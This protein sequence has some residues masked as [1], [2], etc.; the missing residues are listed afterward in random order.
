MGNDI[1]EALESHMGESNDFK[2]IE[3]KEGIV[4]KKALENSGLNNLTG[5]KPLSKDALPSKMMYNSKDSV[6]SIKSADFSE[7][8]YYSSMDEDDPQSVDLAINELLSS[9][10]KVKGG[11]WRDLTLTDKL[12]VF[13]QIRDYTMLNTKSKNEVT[14]DFASRINGEKVTKTV[15]AALFDHHS[16]DEDLMR[17]Y[18]ED[19]RSFVIDL[20]DDRLEIFVPKVG[21]VEG[22]KKYVEKVRNEASMKPEVYLDKNFAVAL[23]YLIKEWRDI[24]DDFTYVDRLK[25]EYDSWSLEKTQVFNHAVSL[26]KVGVKPTLKVKFTN[27]NVEVFPVTFRR[28]KSLFYISDRI[29]KLFPNSK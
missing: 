6:V 27:G 18:N 9:C 24:D 17:L 20:D 3:S 14:I 28:Y 21:V 26:L 10:C 2:K 8:K 19:S 15:N 4:K 11:D 7:I 16:I 23:Q 25:K 13:F 5:W 12:V 29:G 1:E 22:I